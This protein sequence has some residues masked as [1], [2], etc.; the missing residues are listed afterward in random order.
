MFYRHLDYYFCND[1]ATR[2]QCA[3]P[4]QTNILYSVSG[5]PVTSPT[6]AWRRALLGKFLWCPMASPSANDQRVFGVL[7]HTGG[8]DRCQCTFQA[9]SYRLFT[10]YPL[11]DIPSSWN[12]HTLSPSA[13]PWNVQSGYAPNYPKGYSEAHSVSSNC[14]SPILIGICCSSVILS[15]NIYSTNY[16]PTKTIIAACYYLFNLNQMFHSWE[17]QRLLGQR[18]HRNFPSFTNQFRL[19]FAQCRVP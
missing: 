7:R 4:P 13:A 19:I 6:C 15:S 14:D 11:V 3:A 12:G 10:G 9:I 8:V 16:I 18:R 5:V 1:F 17:K 2:L